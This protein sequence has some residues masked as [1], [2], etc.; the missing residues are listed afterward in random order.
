MKKQRYVFSVIIAFAAALTIAG[1]SA[2][3]TNTA[4]NVSNKTNANRPMT[5]ANT[6]LSGN[7]SSNANAAVPTPT[8]K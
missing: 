1:C 6:A 3:S 2:A 5:N 4:A 7:T 8:T